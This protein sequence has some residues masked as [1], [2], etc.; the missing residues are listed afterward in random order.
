MIEVPERNLVDAIANEPQLTL[1]IPH[2]A[3][4]KDD[5]D[6]EVRISATVDPEF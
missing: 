1:L 3:D 2:K 5:D 6:F 4:K